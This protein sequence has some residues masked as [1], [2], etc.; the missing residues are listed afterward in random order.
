VDAEGPIEVRS[1]AVIDGMT[2]LAELSAKLDRVVDQLFIL[3]ETATTQMA[4]LSQM[5]GLAQAAAPM[6][7]SGPAKVLG[8]LMGGRRS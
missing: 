4:V 1:V 5:L 7:T 3:N 8:A 6:M 2:A